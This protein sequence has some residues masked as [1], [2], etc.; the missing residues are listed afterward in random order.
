[1]FIVRII[2]LLMVQFVWLFL[3]FA[4]LSKRFDE[5]TLKREITRTQ[6]RR[7][8]AKVQNKKTYAEQLTNS[9]K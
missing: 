8:K 7:M 4:L 9:V 2:N 6:R 1:M 5:L 3:T